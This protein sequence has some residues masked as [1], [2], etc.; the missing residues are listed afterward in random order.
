MCS[1]SAPQGGRPMMSGAGPLGQ[2]N[3]AFPMPQ[4]PAM[5]VQTSPVQPIQPQQPQAMQPV[6]AP[7]MQPPNGYASQLARGLNRP[8]MSRSIV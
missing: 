8:G 1:A 2:P 7:P 6:Q 5:P 4:R 3:R